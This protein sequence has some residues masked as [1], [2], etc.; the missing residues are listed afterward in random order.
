MKAIKQSY[1][2]LDEINGEEILKR[3]EKIARVCYKSEDKITENSCFKFVKMLVDKGHHAMLEHVSIS[4]KFI[5][6]RACY[7]D[8]T[9]VLTENGWKLFSDLT[10][11]E[12]VATLNDV[13]NVEY[14]PPKDVI[15]YPYEGIMH[16]WR[17]TQID[18]MVT[19]NHN[20]WVFD[21]EKRSPISRVWGFIKSEDMQNGRYKMLKASKGVNTK[22]PGVVVLPEVTCKTGFANDR[23]FPAETYDANDFYELLGWIVTDGCVGGGKGTGTFVCVTQSK[24]KGVS[25]LESLLNRMGLKY[26][27]VNNDYRIRS[28]PLHK[29]FTSKFVKGEDYRKTYDLKMPRELIKSM[30]VEDIKAF[31]RGVINGDGTP[32]SGGKGYQIYTASK[33]FADDLVELAMLAGECANIRIV[34]PRERTFPNG[35]T[36][37]CKEQYVVSIVST[38]ET[39]IK[40]EQ[41]EDVYYSG[42]VYC[43]ELP[44]HHKL[45]VKRNGKAVWCGNCTHE[46]VRHRLASYAQES[47]RYCNY[48][49]NDFGAEIT[50]IEPVY[51]VKGTQAYC[52]WFNAGA[53]S[54]KS[55]FELLEI[56]LTAQEARAVLTNSTK[57]EIVVTANLR[58]W[59]TILKLRT[60]EQAH[61]QMRALMLPLLQELQE[62][63]NV[64]FGGI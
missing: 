27:K 50:V 6:D 59:M 26:S 42:K 38:K 32:H 58:E 15:A 10:G 53:S 64:I 40:R 4:V 5:T 56:G 48:L 1:E 54:E 13:G 17:S 2:I 45:Y 55:Y 31:L 30:S 47:T 18:L 14:L 33:T 12:M 16:Y 29:W 37:M 49:K 23:V 60:S 34:K 63:L 8:K 21:Y 39:L 43:V 46:L 19:P 24:P 41:K 11:V 57:T 35:K 61:P 3:I 28:Q 25:K 20:M 52:N 62:K 22:S 51:L 9:E 44:K 7:D 36:I